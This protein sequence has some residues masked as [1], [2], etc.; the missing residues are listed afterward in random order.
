MKLNR[1]KSLGR[2]NITFFT[3]LVLCFFAVNIG[4][5]TGG[6]IV[7]KDAWVREAPP[8]AKVLAAYMTIENH[9]GTDKVLTGVTSSSFDRIEIHQTLNRDGMASMEQ[10]KELGIAA[11]NSVKLEPGGLHLML[12]NPGAA[13]KA[14]DS[15]TFSLKFA[16][17]GASVASAIVKKSGGRQ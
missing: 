8:N 5:H 10:Q 6:G 1:T 14:G 3:S 7:V 12:F 13:L 16:D 15:I 17:G 4:A 11:E 2:I 9:T